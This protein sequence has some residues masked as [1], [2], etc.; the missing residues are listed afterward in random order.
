MSIRLLN[1]HSLELQEFT[2]ANTPEYVIASHRW[3][4]D[5]CTYK[6][7]LKK[8]NVHKEGYKKVE[9]FCAFVRQHNATTYER[10]PDLRCDWLW[11][12]TCCIDKTNSQEIQRAINSMFKWYSNAVCCYAYLADLEPP[13][14][15]AFGRHAAKESFYRSKWFTRGWTLQEL[16][17]PQT[18]V[19]L[20]RKWEVYG[21]KCTRTRPGSAQL[22]YCPG[23]GDNLNV[24]ISDITSIPQAVLHD[25]ASSKALSVSDRMAWT[26]NRQTS[27]REDMAY[28]LLGIFDVNMTLNYGEGRE[29]ARWR[30]EDEIGNEKRNRAR[31]RKDTDSSSAAELRT[32]P[33]PCTS[34]LISLQ[35]PVRGTANNLHQDAPLRPQVRSTTS[36]KATVESV[37]DEEIT[38][39]K[40]VRVDSPVAVADDEL[41]RVKKGMTRL[42]KRFVSQEALQ[43]LEYTFTEE[44]FKFVVPLALGRAHIDELIRHSEFYKNTKPINYRLKEGEGFT[45]VQADM[46]KMSPS[47]TQGG[48]RLPRRTKS[49]SKTNSEELKPPETLRPRSSSTPKREAPNA[50]AR[51][52]GSKP[53]WP[54][55][56]VDTAVNG[57]GTSDTASSGIGPQDPRRYTLPKSPVQTETMSIHFQYA[58]RPPEHVMESIKRDVGRYGINPEDV[59]QRT[60]DSIDRTFYEIEILA[61]YN[62]L[63]HRAW[64]H[65]IDQLKEVYLYAPDYS[66]IGYKHQVSFDESMSRHSP[67]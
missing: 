12:D 32:K 33:S 45:A 8:R 6:D 19:F 35:Q 5:E 16:L 4:Q 53:L 25:F 24:R 22:S 55:P 1:I 67:Q 13:S 21:H 59:R 10:G 64:D 51:A 47:R 52:G 2:G 11:I 23:A 31:R 66:A 20:T 58:I 34:S 39:T 17:A 56:K 46:R 37:D 57:S 62:K 9:A 61:L 65:L 28:C 3:L 14:N 42:P 27:E 50:E 49:Q 7:V 36:F 41:F 48:D 38:S 44:E 63:S 54:K 29:K 30:L 60:K 43:D 26:R 15:D 18:V 40:P